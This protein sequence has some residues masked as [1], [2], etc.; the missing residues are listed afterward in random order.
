M[1]TKAGIQDCAVVNCASLTLL[2]FSLD[3]KSIY[4]LTAI[5]TLGGGPLPLLPG[6]DGDFLISP[7]FYC[8]PATVSI[9]GNRFWRH[10]G[11]ALP[12]VNGQTKVDE[13]FS[14]LAW[15]GMSWRPNDF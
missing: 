3:V 15:D 1:K 7:M 12:H 4:R 5:Q 11:E 9:R 2:D 10:L 14:R 6:S 8:C 13:G